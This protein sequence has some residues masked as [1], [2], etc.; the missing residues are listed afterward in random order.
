[1][2]FDQNDFMLNTSNFQMQLDAAKKSIFSKTELQVRSERFSIT[3]QI[4]YELKL[5]KI[6]V[7]SFYFQ[8]IFNCKLERNML[9]FEFL[10]IEVMKLNCSKNGQFN[11]TCD[12]D[13]TLQIM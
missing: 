7:L 9:I 10:L 13:L 1:M 6:Q 12:I 5:K 4:I 3:R 2:K 11:L 8:I